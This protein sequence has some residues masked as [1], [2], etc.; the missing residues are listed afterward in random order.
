MKGQEPLPYTAKEIMEFVK[1]FG[2]SNRHLAL[3]VCDRANKRKFTRM[4]LASP[5]ERGKYY[6]EKLQAVADRFE[7]MNMHFNPIKSTIEK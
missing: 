7:Y 6:R 5:I 4:S 3:E 2:Q 1:R